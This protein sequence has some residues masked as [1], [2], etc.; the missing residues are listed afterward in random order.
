MREHKERMP[1]Y[2]SLVLFQVRRECL[3]FHLRRTCL[4]LQFIVCFCSVV[5]RTV[6]T[7]AR[8]ISHSHVD[9]HVAQVQGCVVRIKTRSS[10]C[11]QC[12]HL[13]MSVPHSHLL[14]R[15]LHQEQPL[16]SRCRSINTALLRQKEEPGPLVKTTSSTN[17]PMR[18]CMVSSGAR[19]MCTARR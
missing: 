15:S 8:A 11:H 3:S 18:L 2:S 5:H 6:Y 10:P 16:R 1:P 7:S 12:L 14:P 13:H 17:A 19:C 9:S 4:S